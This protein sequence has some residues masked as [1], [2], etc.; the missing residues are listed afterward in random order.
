M[1]PIQDCPESTKIPAERKTIKSSLTERRLENNSG[2]GMAHSQVF[3]VGHCQG[4]CESC[5]QIF[6]YYVEGPNVIWLLND[7]TSTDLPLILL[8]PSSNSCRCSNKYLVRKKV[9]KE[10]VKR[11][12]LPLPSIVGFLA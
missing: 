1:D 2:R 4:I 9:E 12:M 5:C 11:P 7:P 6:V 8:P 10:T 3:R